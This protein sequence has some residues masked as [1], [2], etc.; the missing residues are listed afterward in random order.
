[1][2]IPSSM[3]IH[4]DVLIDP[5]MADLKTVVHLEAIRY[6]LRAPFLEDQCFDQDPGGG[7]Y[8]IP[9]FLAYQFATNGELMNPD[10]LCNFSSGMSCF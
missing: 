2:E 10:K 6:L 7:F 9:C 8:A 1:M 4:E 5:F 3:F